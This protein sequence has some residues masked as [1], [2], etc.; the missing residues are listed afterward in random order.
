MTVT[1]ALLSE[2]KESSANHAK[3]GFMQNAKVSLTQNIRPCRKLFGSVPIVQK[4]VE[5]RT[6]ELKLFKRYV[7]DIVCTVKG[8]PL[9]YLEY[10]NSLHKNLQFTLE[11]P[12]GS[13]DM[14]FI[15]LNINLNEDRKISC[16]CYQ[17]STDT[18]IILN[19]RSCAPLQHNRNVIL[20]TVHR[21]LLR[22]VTS[23]SLM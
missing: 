11:T 18:G 23:Y 17:K 3:T 8:N 1:D 4:K 13:G 20:G 12:N 22:P 14:A 2:G 5:K 10:A 7:D 15:D 19:F 21:I 16:H 6:L 9:D